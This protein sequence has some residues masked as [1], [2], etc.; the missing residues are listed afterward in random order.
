MS[1]FTAN[2]KGRNKIRIEYKDVG[3]FHGYYVFKGYRKL[4]RLPN[5]LGRM[6]I[7]AQ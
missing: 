3:F 1:D 4:L 7:K 2:P 5:W 6:F